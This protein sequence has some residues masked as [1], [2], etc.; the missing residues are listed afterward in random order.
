[1]NVDLME[2]YYQILFAVGLI[3]YLIF[4]GYSI[5]MVYTGVLE[6]NSS[7]F[8]KIIYYLGV[9]NILLWTSCF[10]LALILRLGRL[11]FS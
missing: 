6:H 8:T 4:S 1:M 2:T 5:Y 9:Y 10:S 3:F 11:L 7:W